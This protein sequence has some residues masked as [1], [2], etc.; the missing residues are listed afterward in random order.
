MTFIVFYYG[1]NLCVSRNAKIINC[2]ASQG[3]FDG[4]NWVPKVIPKKGVHAIFNFV[5]E[6]Q[7]TY[8]PKLDN[9]PPCIRAIGWNFDG[10]ETP[11]FNVV[12]MNPVYPN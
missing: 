2:T 9:F 4:S 12:N 3:E 11:A 10:L 6:A 5:N 8:S 1:A 7:L